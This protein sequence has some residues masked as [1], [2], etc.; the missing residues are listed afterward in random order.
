[1]PVHFCL[2]G[3]LRFI[4]GISCALAFWAISP[5]CL[6]FLR[7]EAKKICLKGFQ[8][9][10]LCLG[11]FVYFLLRLYNPELGV[12][13]SY[14]CAD[15]ANH[16]SMY[17]K[18]IYSVPEAYN[19][20]NALYMNWWFFDKNLN[21]GTV[22]ALAASLTLPLFS[23]SYAIANF[24]PTISLSRNSL[25]RYFLFIC[26][27]VVISETCILPL[28]HYSSADGY[29][30][31]FYSLS[32][33][34]FIIYFGSSLSLAAFL[35]AALS[36]RFSYGLQLPDLLFAAG[37]MLSIKG[38][39]SNERSAQIYLLVSAL[40]LMTISGFALSRLL[41]IFSLSGNIITQ[42]LENAFAAQIAALAFLTACGFRNSL[43]YWFIVA[44]CLIQT[45]WLYST[46]E[47]GY[48]FSKLFFYSSFLIS[49]LLLRELPFILKNKISLKA[50]SWIATLIFIVQAQ[51]PYLDS[52]IER[53]SPVSSQYN[54]VAPLVDSKVSEIIDEVISE[55]GK[56]FSLYFTSRWPQYAFL[57]T[58]YGIPVDFKSFESPPPSL[59]KNSCIFWSNNSNDIAR[60]QKYPA[61]A[62]IEWLNRMN[63][64]KD[65]KTVKY[66]V[67]WAGRQVIKYL[68]ADEQSLTL[69]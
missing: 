4:T 51:R 45:F 33:L 42:N 22:N 15:A 29:L 59:E 52:Y 38:M 3:G 9:I 48:Y 25:A 58:L 30:A 44:V 8:Q 68:C 67:S 65:I 10:L 54:L 18:F 61:V 47:S 28:A 40:I 27:I 62:A 5:A 57:N 17:S 14:G 6:Y 32:S 2:A 60:L 50:L 43:E 12:L 56:S 55:S 23:I 53:T 16:L 24:A 11:L 49:I 19:G 66:Q 13:I 26:A 35:V 36:F 64:R 37:L 69:P 39:R 41:E 1:M 34:I 7:S 20:F 21:L 31:H 63:Q 46:A